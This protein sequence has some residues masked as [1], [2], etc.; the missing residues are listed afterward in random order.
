MVFFPVVI[1]RFW[2]T[3]TQAV[4][5]NFI[6]CWNGDE[7]FADPGLIVWQDGRGLLVRVTID[8]LQRKE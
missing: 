1:S 4:D 2:E 5:V 7:L 3:G 6:M 8:S